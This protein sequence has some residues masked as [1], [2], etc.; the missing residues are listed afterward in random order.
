MSSDVRYTPLL[1]R[2]LIAAIF[3]LSGFGKLTA[4]A[5]TAGYIAAV[6]LPLPYLGVI[7]AILVELVGGLLLIAGYQ[8][9]L[10]ALAMAV[11]S[12][13]A[14]AFFHNNLGDQNQFIHF[15]KNIAMAGG[16]LQIVAFGAGSLS[17]DAVL[18][19]KTVATA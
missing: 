9:R 18:N 12:V 13:A 14:A 11:F 5:A 19:R 7:I 1:G 2:V 3:L 8:T 15:F 10:V 16:L 6:G 17:V 4:P